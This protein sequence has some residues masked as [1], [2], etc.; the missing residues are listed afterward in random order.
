MTSSSPPPASPASRPDSLSCSQ[1]STTGESPSGGL[2]I[3]SA[4]M[5]GAG[6]DVDLLTLR[7]CLQG[8]FDGLGGK[9]TIRPGADADLILVNLRESFVV[10]PEEMFTQ[11]RDIALPFRGKRLYGRIKKT[12]LRGHLLFDEGRIVADGGWGRWITGRPS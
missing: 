12:F 6:L 4:G 1:P 5:P 10:R 9:G 7:S 2:W 11:A 8:H 3:S